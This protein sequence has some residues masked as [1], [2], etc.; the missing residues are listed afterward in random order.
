MCMD[1][2]GLEHGEQ[3]SLERAGLGRDKDVHTMEDVR[4]IDERSEVALQ[5]AHLR[6]CA[7][8][9]KQELNGDKDL[10]VCW[11]R[12]MH[13][14]KALIETIKRSTNTVYTRAALGRD[15]GVDTMEQVRSIGGGSR[16]RA[17]A[18]LCGHAGN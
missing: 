3:S 12:A 13:H 2:V 1:E 14:W 6:S 10:G 11:T 18:V 9:S 4:S 15:K 8:G 17:S 7:H 5:G 16:V